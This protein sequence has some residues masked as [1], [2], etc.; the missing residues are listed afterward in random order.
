MYIHAF[1]TETPC[2]FISGTVDLV[3]AAC[4]FHVMYP[5]KRCGRVITA[6]F[7]FS[8]RPTLSTTGDR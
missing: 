3:T 6:S 5:V 4:F 1:R 2:L 7:H 8:W